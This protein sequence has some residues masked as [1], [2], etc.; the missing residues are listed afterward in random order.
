MSLNPGLGDDSEVVGGTIANCKL[1][2]ANWWDEWEAERLICYLAHEDGGR[3]RHL[4]WI[5]VNR[6]HHIVV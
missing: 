6:E 4:D 1:K 3:L 5:D 2:N